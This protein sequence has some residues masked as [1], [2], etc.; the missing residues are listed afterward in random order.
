MKKQD[1]TKRAAALAAA[2]AVQEA[3]DEERAPRAQRRPVLAPDG[4]VIRDAL[5]EEARWRDPEDANLSARQAREVRGF[6]RIDPLQALLDSGRLDRSQV[7]AA[8]RFRS[9]NAV[10]NGDTGSRPWMVE[11][12]PGHGTAHG[13]RIEA[14]EAQRRMREAWQ[15]IRGGRSD[16]EAVWIADAV[17]AVVLGWASCARYDEA[18]R[19]REGTCRARLIEGLTRLRD[20]YDGSGRQALDAAAVRG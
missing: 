1:K 8:D 6:R 17:R 5:I 11:H 10:A 15:A 14:V 16:L 13:P 2:A 9:D 19:V 7:H 20:H 18:R 3:L 12:V 4:T